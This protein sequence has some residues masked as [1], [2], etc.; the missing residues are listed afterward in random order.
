MN[1][2]HL[3]SEKG[4][5]IVYLVLGLVVFLGFVA[6]AI[7]GGMVLADRRDAQNA[8]DASALAGASAAAQQLGIEIVG[9]PINP[10]CSNNTML[11]L[12]KTAAITAAEDRADSNHYDISAAPNYVEVKCGVNNGPFMD[13]SVQISKHTPT[14]FLQVLVPNANLT[15]KM[16]STARLHTAWTLGGGNAIVALNTGSSL[17]ARGS[18]KIFIFGGGVFGNGQCNEANSRIKVYVCKSTMAAPQE[19]IDYCMAHLGE[20]DP[21]YQIIDN[22]VNIHQENYCSGS[23]DPNVEGG[24]PYMDPAPFELPAPDC[25]GHDIYSAADLR[26]DPLPGLYCV[27][28][29]RTMKDY[30]KQD[31]KCPLQEGGICNGVTFYLVDK[32]DNFD[33]NGNNTYKLA[34]P[35]VGTAPET[36][37]GAIPGVLFY[38]SLTNKSQISLNGGGGTRLYGS[39]LLPGADILQLNGNADMVMKGMIAVGTFDTSGTFDGVIYYDAQYVPTFSALIDLLH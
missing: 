32:Q 39:W 3:N 23:F 14:S 5:A 17:Y 30:L 9:T 35:V 36:T 10:D 20:T 6:L 7:D 15:N 21:L 34:A 11:T 4:Q 16:T 28:G 27:H 22:S 1:T 26:H 29:N 25:T 19:A 13:V 18:S 37:N 38:A 31:V 8:T 33:W 2:K 24:A 12:A